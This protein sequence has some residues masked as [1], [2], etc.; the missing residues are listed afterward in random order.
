MCNY[1]NIFHIFHKPLKLYAETDRF[2][3]VIAIGNQ[4]Y[5]DLAY[6]RKMLLTQRADRTVKRQDS[7]EDELSDDKFFSAEEVTS[8]Q[9]GQ[10]AQA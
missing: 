5:G 4:V 1:I 7:D 3:C 6:G 2:L 8:Y 9:I 10:T